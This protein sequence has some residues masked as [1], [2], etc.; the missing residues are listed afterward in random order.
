MVSRNLDMPSLCRNTCSTSLDCCLL[1]LTHMGHPS[2]SARMLLAFASD[3]V[4]S[5][6]AA[7]LQAPTA[8]FR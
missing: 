5:M 8:M 4:D 1:M 7:H 2:R 6:L 3:G